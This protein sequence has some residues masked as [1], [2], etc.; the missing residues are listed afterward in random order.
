MSTQ[1]VEEDEKPPLL[2]PG[3][4]TCLVTTSSARTN[5]LLVVDRFFL[6]DRSGRTA[7]VRYRYIGPVQPGTDQSRLNSNFNSNS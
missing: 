5:D 4:M 2:P 1:N 6:P 7:V 3:Q